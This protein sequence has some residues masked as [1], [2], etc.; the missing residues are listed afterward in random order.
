MLLQLIKE[1]PSQCVT[2]VSICNEVTLLDDSLR[3]NNTNINFSF[4]TKY[5]TWN[6]IVCYIITNI[7]NW[8]INN[9]I[10]WPVMYYKGSCYIYQFNSVVLVL[11][12]RWLSSHISIAGKFTSLH[13]ASVLIL[14][15]ASSTI[16]SAV[17]NSPWWATYS[18]DTWNSKNNQ[19]ITYE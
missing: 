7:D 6:V 10:P 14:H 2:Y 13:C 18:S 3:N 8:Y 15:K 5:A 1:T 12:G 16:C 19:H 9:Y 4:Y 17:P 11:K